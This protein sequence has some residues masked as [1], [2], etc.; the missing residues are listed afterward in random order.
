MKKII[1]LLI[2]TLLITGCSFPTQDD[3]PS[4]EQEK[5]QQKVLQE[6]KGEDGNLEDKLNNITVNNLGSNIVEI[7]FNLP[8]E[9]S[10]AFADRV[11]KNLIVSIRDTIDSMGNQSNTIHSSL[12]KYDLPSQ[13]H[14]IIYQGDTYTDD[15][16]SRLK[17]L[18]NGD[19]A[20]FASTKVLFLE[21][22][23]FK[24]IS[25]KDLPENSYF[26]YD[27]SPD[28]SKI[29]MN[30]FDNGDLSLTDWNFLDWK[31]LVKSVKSSDSDGMDGKWPGSPLWS[32][33]GTQISYVMF[34]YE[35]S[36]GVGVVDIEGKNSKFFAKKNPYFIPSYTYWLDD[37]KRILAVQV[38]SDSQ[39]YVITL[40]HGNFRKLEIPESID[41][42]I[43]NPIQQKAAVIAKN[44]VYMLDLKFNK[45]KPIAPVQ[46]WVAGLQWDDTG[47]ELIALRNNKIRIITLQD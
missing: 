12:I 36:E 10:L 6:G 43:P 5:E 8:K 42:L 11:G 31:S 19:I 13:T 28:G 7:D 41:Y 17:V 44:Q 46:D 24:L 30:N 16:S 3:T 32:N 29:V 39:V 14:E 47:S 23:S 1:A 22:G 25:V 37:D 20:F 26:H 15:F 21:K 27:I 2:F 35:S 9:Y 4:S 38:G 45:I 33:D 18:Q 34:L 40:A